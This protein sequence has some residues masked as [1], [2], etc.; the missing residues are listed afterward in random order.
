MR[1]ADV[2]LGGAYGRRVSQPLHRIHSAWRSSRRLFRLALSR[3]VRPRSFVTLMVLGFI[4]VAVPLS[5]AFVAS[6]IQLEALASHG[7]DPVCR[8]VQAARD[9]AD[10]AGDCRLVRRLRE[11]RRLWLKF[12]RCCARF[13][14][15]KDRRPCWAA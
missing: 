9:V 5:T 4:T 1:A 2:G 7:R 10:R 13:L 6:S 12:T 15:T 8:A 14:K 11:G 3:L